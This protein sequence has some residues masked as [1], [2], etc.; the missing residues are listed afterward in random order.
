MRRRVSII[1]VLVGGIAAPYLGWAMHRASLS[2]IASDMS[3]PRPWLY[4]DGW[5]AGLAAW[6]DARN[7]AP[8]DTIKIHGELPRV[9]ATM[10]LCFVAGVWFLA[11]G[12]RGLQI[13]RRRGAC[14]P[15]AQPRAGADPTPP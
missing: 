7:P 8:A 4:P 2:V 1:M 15:G 5:L 13:R 12:I 14:R 10:A 11:L 9:G 6:Y 3:W